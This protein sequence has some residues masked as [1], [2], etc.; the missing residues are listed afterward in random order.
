MSI[1][2]ITTRR[3]F[4]R[5]KDELHQ[6]YPHLLPAWHAF[7]DARAHRRAVEWLAD[8]DNAMRFLDE[9][10]EPHVP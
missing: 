8:D 2:Q 9:H 5:F 4:R 1:R 6:E 3:A 10:P 7:R